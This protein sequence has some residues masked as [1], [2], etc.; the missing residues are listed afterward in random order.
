MTS[1][2]T[3]AGVHIV[4]GL[5]YRLL[6]SFMAQF[7]RPFDFQILHTEYSTKYANLFKFDSPSFSFFVFC[8]FS[9]LPNSILVF[10]LFSYS[11]SLQRNRVKC[12]SLI[13]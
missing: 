4:S 5:K 6:I 3:V 1:G 7:R 10:G 11:V 13:E 12:L 9:S 8:I 2:V